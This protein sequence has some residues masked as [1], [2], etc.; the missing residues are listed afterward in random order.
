LPDPERRFGVTTP[1]SAGIAV[2]RN[3]IKRLLKETFR[4]NPHRFPATGCLLV[5]IKQTADEANLGDELI[6][7]TE[8]AVRN[9]QNR[10]RRKDS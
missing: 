4:L 2:R 9:F 1:R 7:L 5:R 10:Q 6:G 8:K 3:R